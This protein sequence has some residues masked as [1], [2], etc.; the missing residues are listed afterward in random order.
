M[1]GDSLLPTI[2]STILSFPAIQGNEGKSQQSPEG[3]ENEVR[4]KGRLRMNTSLL[5]HLELGNGQSC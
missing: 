2:L 1:R 5:R 4:I 3:G